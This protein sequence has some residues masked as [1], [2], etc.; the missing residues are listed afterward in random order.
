M[1]SRVIVEVHGEGHPSFLN[2][3]FV[4]FI[5]VWPHREAGQ[6]QG[7]A[8]FMRTVEGRTYHTGVYATEADAIAAVKRWRE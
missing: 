4:V 6:D 7:W 5:E 2:I 3:D 1:S 8:I